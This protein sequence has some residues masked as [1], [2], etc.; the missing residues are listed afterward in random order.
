MIP[1]QR[2]HRDTPEHEIPDYMWFALWLFVRGQLRLEQGRF[3]EAVADFLEL[4]RR[5]GRWGL[6]G[7]PA[8]QARTYTARALA[9]LG[10]HDQ[11]RVVG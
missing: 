1:W 4:Q 5:A 7:M 11:A 2:H 6:I 8:L 10:R 9:A 3:E